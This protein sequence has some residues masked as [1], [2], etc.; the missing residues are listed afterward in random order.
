MRTIV[1]LARMP[2]LVAGLAC[3][4]LGCTGEGTDDGSLRG[5]FHVYVAMLENGTSRVE[6]R[7]RVGD[8]ERNVVPLV[9][10]DAAELTSG[11][12]V[13]VWGRPS[14]DGFVVMR[15]EALE[16]AT[17]GA[18]S[19]A[20]QRLIDGPPFPARDLAFVRVDIGGGI[21]VSA[22]SAA[23]DV[24]GTN[25]GDA[26]VRQLY[27]E[28]S[29][30]RQDLTGSVVGPFTHSMNECDIDELTA[31]LRPGVDAALGR[32]SAQYLWYLGSRN[33]ACSWLGYGELGTPVRPARD[34]W[35]NA[36]P[37]CVLT[38]ETGHN[39]GLRHASSFLCADG[40][41]FQDDP[42]DTTC[43]ATGSTCCVSEYGDV[44]S[45]MGGGCFHFNAWEKAY[46]GW[47]GGCNSVRVN[48]SGTFTLLP[49]E[50]ECNGVQVL[51]IPMPVSSR[52]IEGEAV[53]FYY[54][55]LRARVGFDRPLAELPA[56]LVRVGAGYPSVSSIGSRT[57][58]LDMNPATTSRPMSIDGMSVGQTF[59]DPAGGVSFTLRALS[60]ASATIEVT[61]PT[62]APN[63]CIGGGT[64][65]PPGPANCGDGMAGA[66]GMGG[67]A[68]A[69]GMG[70]AAGAGGRGGAGGVGGAGGWSGSTFGAGTSAGG[71]SGSA[72][73]GGAGPDGEGGADGV[74]GATGGLAGI[75]GASGGVGGTAGFGGQSGDTHG[76]AGSGASESGGE[77]GNRDGEG[78]EPTGDAG[79]SGRGS[80]TA[81]S[82][83]GNGH[84]CEFR[85]DQRP[86]R[87]EA[88]GI[89]ALLTAVAV[90]VARRRVRRH[91]P[92][93]ADERSQASSLIA[94]A[95]LVA[96]LFG[97][98][99]EPRDDGSVRGTLE[100]HVAMLSDGTSRAEYHLRVGGPEREDLALVFVEPPELT[101]G[102]EVKVWGRRTRDGFAVSKLDVVH[103]AAS[104]AVGESRQA[105]IDGPAFPDRRI[106][107]VR[108]DIGRGIELS[109]ESAAIDLFGMEPLDYST[110]QYFLE[111]SYG[112]QDIVGAVVGPFSYTMTGCDYSALANALKPQVDAA[113][114]ATPAHYFWYFG[115]TNPNCVWDALTASG[116]P[117]AP[118][119]NNWFNGYSTSSC[120]FLFHSPLVNRGEQR[121][122]S[123]RCAEG[124]TFVD[125]PSNT[126]TAT[127]CVPT[128][129]T[130]CDE[131]Y[132]DPSDVL[133]GCYH[134]S[135]WQKAYQ[136]WFGGCNSVRVNSSGT[137][138]LLPLEIECSG[139]QV[140]QI[141]MPVTTRTIRRVTGI[142][143]YQ[144]P[145][146]YYYL[147]LRTR[148]GFDQP[149]SQA[150]TVFVRVGPE[151]AS[152]TDVGRMTWLL[153]MSP[154]TT[155][156]SSFDG[157]Q[158]GQTFTDPAGGVSFTLRAM[159]S[160]SATIDVTV[161]TNSA[162]TCAGGGTLTSPGPATCSGEGGGAGTGG[163]AG[164]GS[165][166]VGGMGG[167]AGGA[168]GFGGAAGVGGI[169][170]DAGRGGLSGGGMS[171]LS[172]LGGGG[173]AGN[174]GTGGADGGGTGEAGE[175][176]EAG[177]GAGMAGRVGTGGEGTA[178]E[179]AGGDG[180]SG[181]AA[182]GGRA[183]NAGAGGGASGRAGAH[184][185]GTA[186]AGKGSA[187]TDGGGDGGGCR[188]ATTPADRRSHGAPVVLGL[189]ALVSLVR[190]RRQT[191]RS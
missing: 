174:A 5:T 43:P 142:T 66:A 29:Y 160:S 36:S 137:F 49:L 15:R 35:V 130:C 20:E 186:H 24:F 96:L 25:L 126:G 120:S 38:H 11:D 176:G 91:R 81:G 82:G 155:H 180:S 27:L 104:S 88:A 83:D 75:S 71:D 46:Q 185:G 148:V 127:N 150:P 151:Y 93:R 97:C 128:A 21:N 61:V 70:G 59:V 188:L 4:L 77:A 84:G 57:F 33:S 72:G 138:T 184:T 26:S 110:K 139:I 123:L 22:E 159:S 9:I 18:V 12:E 136:G 165:G 30:G 1:A 135:A 108:V 178:G 51:Q 92:T 143:T 55:E 179:N 173:G 154:A 158:V 125:D 31:A 79:E 182:D 80:G 177:A 39:F 122:S 74:A 42:S 172:G 76:D 45:P 54:L 23:M 146:Q 44:F 129:T 41:S 65:T 78:G 144:D 89:F 19:R 167:V 7:L 73:L 52:R 111:A 181:D 152:S 101:A 141:P 48:S 103:G 147:E 109:A 95:P 113:M 68:G 191:R 90:V 64:L 163:A 190:R 53:Q 86:S 13:K 189:A 60:S 118:A 28:S 32:S 183:G 145:V 171:G 6:Y 69:S 50:H 102:S 98:S 169:G 17:S 112:R 133:N 162:N 121:S 2:L 156:W 105:L 67:A 47:F 99:E 170:G 114:G 153:D 40:T 119:T 187:G 37:N 58:L 106:A 164:G 87:N 140:L 14:A 157:M 62:T 100:V 161:P 149:M 116:R 134:P 131:K 168:S 8:D 124:V 3:G 16:K 85:R 10:D 94:L 117:T 175:A 34:T 166:G 132:G 107:F 56:V 115:S 63:T